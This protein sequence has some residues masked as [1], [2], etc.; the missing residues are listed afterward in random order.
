[1]VHKAL[2]TYKILKKEN[3][4]TEI[5]DITSI[6]PLDKETILKSI[7]KTNCAVTVEDH[8][9]KN[10]MGVRISQLIASE[11]PVIVKNLGV[12]MYG[13]TGSSEELTIKHGLEVTDIMKLVKETIQKK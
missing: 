5:I 1:M 8:Y 13:R 2:D 12:E 4:S 7:K 6:N 9:V 10:G 11:Y 3:I